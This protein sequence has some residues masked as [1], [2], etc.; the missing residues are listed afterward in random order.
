MSI[1]F[2]IILWM[3]SFVGIQAVS[4]A[5]P[6]VDVKRGPRAAEFHGMHGQMND[7]LAELADLQ[8]KYRTADEDQRTDIQQKWKECFAKGEKLEPQWIE[9]AEQA[10][11]EAPNT[12]P[13]IAELLVKVLTRKVQSDDDEPGPRSASC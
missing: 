4:A 3:V 1:R 2:A 11:A 6:P 9:A 5:D 10:Y 13:S 7:I 8:V 12:D